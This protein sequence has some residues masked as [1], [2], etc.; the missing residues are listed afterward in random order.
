M[1]SKGQLTVPVKIR[2][3]LKLVPGSV[4]QFDEDAAFL[5]ARPVFD[6]Q[7]ARAVLGCARKAL[8]GHTAES[9]LAATRGRK[10]K[11]RK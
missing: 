9:W 10:V 11:L 4:L 2:R 3:K 6:E 8:P 7:K 5:K 1:T